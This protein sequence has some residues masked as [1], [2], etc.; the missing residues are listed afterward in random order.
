MSKQ[1][2]KQKLFEFDDFDD[3]FEYDYDGDWFV[4]PKGRKPRK[5]ARG[6][7]EK[8]KSAYYN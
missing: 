3:E 8:Y 5:T 6:Q 4:E 2:K 7:S 1:S